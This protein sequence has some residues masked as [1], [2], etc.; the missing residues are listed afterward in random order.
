MAKTVHL[1]TIGKYIT[2]ANMKF[3]VKKIMD[4]LKIKRNIHLNKNWIVFC[5][6]GLCVQN[7]TV[8]SCIV[9]KI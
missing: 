1:N 8:V 9:T 7:L 5:S 3:L 4:R 6:K 2:T